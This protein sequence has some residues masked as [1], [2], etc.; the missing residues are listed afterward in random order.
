MGWK[1]V[2]YGIKGLHGLLIYGD[3][4]MYLMQLTHPGFPL[5]LVSRILQ[6]LF[7]CQFTKGGHQS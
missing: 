1:T 6:S 3:G 4:R 7:F 5:Y 2:F